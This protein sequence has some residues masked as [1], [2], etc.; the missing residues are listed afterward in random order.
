MLKGEIKVK[1]KN[2]VYA[3]QGID[4]SSMLKLVLSTSD[5]QGIAYMESA[6][7]TEM[8]A[9]ALFS[10]G[11][12]IGT[13]KITVATADMEVNDKRVK[14]PVNKEFFCR[15]GAFLR[16]VKRECSTKNMAGSFGIQE[17]SGSVSF[18]PEVEYSISRPD[19]TPI[20]NVVLYYGNVR[21]M[22][23]SNDF[24]DVY[25]TEVESTDIIPTIKNGVKIGFAFQ[26]DYL[27]FE[28]PQTQE[29][30]TENTL[31]DM[32]ATLSEVIEA[33]PDKEF[34][35]LRGKDYRIVTDEDLEQICNYIYD[36]GEY[37]YFDT[38]TS[39]LNINFK[40]RTGDADQCVGIILSI[41]DGESFY[42]P[43]QMKQ[44]KN[45]CGGDHFYFMEHYIRRILENKPIVVH[46]ASFDWKVAYIYDINTNVVDDTFAL[47]NMTLAQEQRDMPTGLKSLTKMLLHRDSLELSDLVKGNE[48]GEGEV[49]FWDLPAELTRFYACADTDNT[50]GIHRYA[51]DNN[52]LQKYNATKVYEIEVAFA[53][54]VGYQEFY[55][56][57]ID[58]KQLDAMRKTLQENLD[59]Y[60]K[61]MKDMVGHD[62][63]PNSPPQL[64]KVLYQEM[65][66]PEQISRKTGR[67]TTDKETLKA[68]GELQDIDGKTKYPFC[69]ALLKYREYE[70]VRK[71][72]D[73]FPETMTQDGY[74]FSDV[75][76]YGTTTGRVSIKSPN[77]QSYN[78]PVKQ[79]VVPRPGYYMFD[80]DYSSVEYRVLG[81]MAGNKMIK[82]AFVDPDF[83]YHTYQA[84]RM[85][86]VPYASV[87]GKLRKAA[88]G[89]NFGLP[90][91][92]G[93]QSLGVRIFGEESQENTKK[94]A[95]LRKAYFK[96]Q[97]DIAD[98]FEKH[99]D[100]GVQLGYTETYFGRRRY[101]DKTKF[102][103]NSIRRQAGNAVIQGTSADIYKLAVGRVFK[104]ICKEGWLGKVLMDGFIHDELLGEVS[105]DIDPVKFLKVLREEFEVK[106]TD[107]D[108]TPWCPLYMGFGW[109]MSWYQAK[110]TEVPIKLQW[111]LVDKYGEK[112]YPGWDGNGVTF[113]DSIPDKIREFSIRDSIKQIT[114]TESQGKQIKPALNSEILEIIK[115]DKAL[116]DEYFADHDA[117]DD[118][119]IARMHIS[120]PMIRE[121]TLVR[122]LPTTSDTQ[123][124]LDIF[125]AIHGVDRSGV[126][127]L[128]IEDAN[129]AN[130]TGGAILVDDDDDVDTSMEQRLMEIITER[131][132]LYGLYVDT[133]VNEIYC[134][135]PIAD[136]VK[137]YIRDVSVEQPQG[138][139][140]IFLDTDNGVKYRTER[141][142]PDEYVT[143]V[144]Q[145]YLSVLS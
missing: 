58:I 67:V 29:T 125:C 131:V 94:A 136:N 56:H 88:K 92:M 120:T 81:N 52:L 123:E 74:I 48:W 111:E 87:S 12:D 41:V 21:S 103:V 122:E 63:N 15:L 43:M 107:V 50:R 89:I 31:S 78:N 93:D 2:L 105:T 69:K 80:T 40:S 127:V 129:V 44:I 110:S 33:H 22:V 47:Y 76:Q 85:Y 36:E 42:F 106:I 55:G 27:G 97:E 75:M 45:L 72:V 140:I 13:T 99:R 90:Y 114:A 96:G 143:N 71:I 84:A 60:Y 104:R 109:G 124:A 142:L 113:S 141:Y 68:L 6:D 117:L 5:S 66:I 14:A 61:E 130:A 101:Y 116:Y 39:G 30:V 19:G 132:R 70:G 16:Y 139:R 119:A 77:Y 49:L 7:A 138:F 137:L 3:V 91:G 54:A 112:G 4:Y 128:S 32:Y 144:Q 37:V 64:Q 115:E 133:R 98:F 134:K 145:V 9:E 121:G 1:D 126:N 35:W 18:S 51:K 57:H 73:K 38:E 79:N 23:V 8:T 108:G 65:G 17:A 10:R 62:F 24:F 34:E 118:D 11:I 26:K 100:M 95:A 53:L 46:N 82:E 59:K 86:G 135:Y 25:L 20:G 28:I 102:S 83:D